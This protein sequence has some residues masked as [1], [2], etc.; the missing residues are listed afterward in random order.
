MQHTA[1]D[2]IMNYFWRDPT[3]SRKESLMEKNIKRIKRVMKMLQE[4]YFPN[5]TLPKSKRNINYR[6]DADNGRHPVPH[7]ENK[8]NQDA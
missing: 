4:M 2:I 1:R 3:E 5:L 8:A 6:P 7:D